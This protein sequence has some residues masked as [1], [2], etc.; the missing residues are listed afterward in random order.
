MLKKQDVVIEGGG[1]ARITRAKNGK[2][3]WFHVTLVDKNQ[4]K[5]F[6]THNN[7]KIY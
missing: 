7:F 6:T 3:K 2:Q 5:K 1:F 4:H